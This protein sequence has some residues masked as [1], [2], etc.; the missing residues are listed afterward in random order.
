MSVQA[1]DLSRV[2]EPRPPVR[3]A[4]GTGNWR[5]AWRRLRRNRA[6]MTGGIVFLVILFCCF[7]GAPLWVH[8]AA[9]RGPE[10]QNMMGTISAGGHKV[11]V[12]SADGTPIGPGLRGQYLLG[13]DTNGRDLFVRVLY[14]GRISLFVGVAS[15]ALCTLLALL[16]AIPAGYWGGSTD[17]IVSGILDLI[18]SFPV[19]LLMVAI[20]ASLL[21]SGVNL[22]PIHISS[23]SLLIPILVIAV[24]MIP[25]VARPIRGEVLALREREFVEAAIAHGA[26]PL[27]VMTREILPNVMATTLVMFTLIIANNILVLAGLSFIGVGVSLLTP[28]WGNII[29]SGFSQIVT[30]PMQTV[31]PGV[32][33]LLTSVALNVFGD[34]LRDALDPHGSGRTGA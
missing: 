5:L 29:Q 28:E 22:G 32:A 25:Y 11:P 17:R 9:H 2:A 14:G 16:L 24:V 13:A 6:A 26:G 8:F 31:A 33:I 23:T 3:A 12:I 20:S 30:S 1:S 15:S 19:F 4:A 10:V 18:W 27:R 34:G 21:V 7:P